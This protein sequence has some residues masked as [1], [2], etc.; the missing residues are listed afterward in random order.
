MTC[1]DLDDDMVIRT[2]Q[3]YKVRHSTTKYYTVLQSITPYDTVLQSITPFDSPTH[4]TPS[5][6]PEATG[7]TLEFHQLW[8]LPRKMFLMIDPCLTWNVQYNARSNRSH[9]P[10]SPNCACHENWLSWFIGVTYETSLTMRGATGL[11]LQRHQTLHLPR[12]MTLMIDHLAPARSPSLLFALP[13]RILYWNYNISRSGYLPKFH[14][15]LRLPRKV[16]L[17]HHQILR[18]PRKAKLQQM[19]LDWTVTRLNFYFS[20]LLLDWTG[21]WLNCYFS[22]LLLDWTGTWLKYCLTE[23]LPDFTELLLDWTVTWLHCYFTELLLYWVLRI[24]KS[25]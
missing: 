3:Y 10:T 9:P 2:T 4:E 11:A 7:V 18:L 20:R 17:Q 14:L 1:G 15:I 12:K 5:T 6:I 23:L 16:T 22:Q 25:P 19:L 24:L 13:S 8:R 21:T